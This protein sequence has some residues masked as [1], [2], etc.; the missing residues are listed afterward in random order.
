MTSETPLDQ[1]H[2]GTGAKANTEAPPQL[3]SFSTGLIRASLHN[4]GK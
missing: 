1:L 4:A 3:I 2:H